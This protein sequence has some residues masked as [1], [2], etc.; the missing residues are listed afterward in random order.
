ML[1]CTYIKRST[2]TTKEL[3]FKLAR[4]VNQPPSL[5][6]QAEVITA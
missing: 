4:Q 6:I 3:T 1:H 2:L 5:P